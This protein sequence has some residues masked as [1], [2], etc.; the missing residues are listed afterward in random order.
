MLI[1]PFTAPVNASGQAVVSIGHSLSQI[2]WKVYQIGF[3]LGKLAP[4][5]QVAAHVNSVPLASTTTMQPS[6]F[7]NIVGQ[8]PYAMESF[9]VGPPYIILSSGDTITC[10]VL[11]ATSGDVFT[12]AAY[13]EEYDASDSGSLLMG[14]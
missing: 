9:F 8:A 10:A 7:A 5:P 13:I 12:A 14:Q 2:A 11:A 6:V 1:K 3:G 4:S